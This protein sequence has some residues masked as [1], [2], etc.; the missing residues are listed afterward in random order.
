MFADPVY[1]QDEIFVY[2]YIAVDNEGRESWLQRSFLPS[3]GLGELNLTQLYFSGN[4][5]EF[6]RLIRSWIEQQA[7]EKIVMVK[8]VKVEVDIP[9]LRQ[10][11]YSTTQ[12]KPI[13]TVLRAQ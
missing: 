7:E 11:H 2:R 4:H 9:K 12:S 1:V 13:V 10:G 8:L 5:R 3:Y 6:E